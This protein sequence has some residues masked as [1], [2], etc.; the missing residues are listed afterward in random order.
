MKYF[1]F[2]CLIIT[3]ISSLADS[4]E[5]S[6]REFKSMI[7]DEHR[8]SI[9]EQYLANVGKYLPV[10]Q[11]GDPNA[12]YELYRNL[13]LL[14]RIYNHD[15]A[16]AL[17]IYWLNESAKSG[18]TAA[19]KDL[20]HIHKNGNVE[21]GIEKDLVKAAEYFKL[22]ADKGDTSAETEYLYI[23]ECKLAVQKADDC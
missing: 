23:T 13:N 4:D 12:M 11:A 9:Y 3:S 21:Y 10:A 17:A 20:G 8:Q 22:A 7:T 16:S 1:L 19:L 15:N 5:S 2:L 14:A 6:Y 18:H